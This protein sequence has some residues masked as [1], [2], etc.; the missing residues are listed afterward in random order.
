MSKDPTTRDKITKPHAHFQEP[1][2]VVVDPALSK[3]EKK[4]AL[5]SMEQ[6]ARQL[7][8]ASTEGMS[9][10][11]PGKLHEV[12]DAKEA[13]ELPAVTYAYE[14]VAKDLRSSLE[15]TEN[16]DEWSEIEQAIT[17]LDAVMRR[18]A[19]SAGD[20]GQQAPDGVPKPG[21]DAEL[22]EEMAKE[23]LDP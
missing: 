4:Q 8:T 11:E 12:L 18:R 16:Q 6:D 22:D 2:E 13:L 5:E 10:G 15:Q 7:L 20:R 9:G 14:V 19:D 1:E 23:K 17:A 3:D 21:S